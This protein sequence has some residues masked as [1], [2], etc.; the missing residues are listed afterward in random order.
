MLITLNYNSVN[1]DFDW[2][3][4]ILNSV[5]EE[6]QMNVVSK[7]FEL[8]EVKHINNNLNKFEKVFINNLRS[9]YWS[10]FKNKNARFI[11]SSNI[12]K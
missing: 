7:C 5:E 9:K 3:L 6:S 4:R 8:W 1:E 2:V 10:Q 11:L 12:R